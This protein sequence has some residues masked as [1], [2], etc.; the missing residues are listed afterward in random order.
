MESIFETIKDCKFWNWDQEKLRGVDDCI[1]WFDLKVKKDFRWLQKKFGF[2][3][4]LIIES[5]LNLKPSRSSELRLKLLQPFIEQDG[6]DEVYGFR[7]GKKEFYCTNS[8]QLDEIIAIVTK[9]CIL[10]T[11]EEDFAVIKKIGQ[12]STSTVYLIE[13]LLTHMQYAAKCINKT[14]LLSRPSSLSNLINEIEILSALSHP[15]IIHLHHIYETS[16]SVNLVLDYLPHGD[17]YKR[18]S[19]QKSFSDEDCAKLAR[20][21]IETLD[22][23]QSKSIVHR[24]LKLENIVMTAENNFSFKIIDFGLAAKF[25]CK[26]VG[27][28]G[29][30][31]YI[32]P[33]VIEGKEYDS[34][35]DVFS[36]GVIIY[37]CL[38][39]KHPFNASSTMKI[40][41]K[42]L[43]CRVKFDGI[44]KG[45]AKELVINMMKKLPQDRLEPELLLD[46][47]WMR[48]IRRGSV[49]NLLLSCSTGAQSVL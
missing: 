11:F 48:G 34:K 30:P 35:A 41:D 13:D 8:K 1:Y 39:G 9:S 10:D 26:L 24:D 27:R 6:P 47:N 7:L 18:L 49:C 28:C 16:E 38:T 46:L 44:E 4:G 3:E 32:A 2:I 45:L 14:Y 22:Y 29:S 37:I 21:L 20:N 23:L 15:N 19:S 17:L 40:L 25:K 31:G 42:N 43:E 12:G 36:A 5:D 33:E